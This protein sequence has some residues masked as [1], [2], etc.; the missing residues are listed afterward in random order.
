MR[1]GIDCLQIDQDDGLEQYI[2]SITDGNEEDLEVL[3]DLK[4]YEVY[5]SLNA[6]NQLK[7][8]N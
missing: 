3:A 2:S 8:E 1:T 6:K 4:D 5:T 7:G